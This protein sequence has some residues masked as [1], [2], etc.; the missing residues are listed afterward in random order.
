VSFLALI[1]RNVLRHK[2]RSS[3]TGL[4]VAVAI[5]A[6]FALGVLTH[7]LRVTAISIL[8]TGTADFSVGQKGVSDILYS[9][10]DETEVEDLASYPGVESV[11][12]VLVA[13]VDLDKDHPFFLELGIEPDKLT[14][15]GVQVVDGEPYHPDATDE[16]MLGYRAARDLNKGVGDTLTVEDQQQ[17]F[18]VVGIFSTGQVFGDS[19]SMLPLLTLQG[20]ERKP[21]IITLA[22]VKVKEGVDIDT[23]RA[24]I[25]KEN[26]QLAT[27][28][29][30]SE[31]GRIDRNLKLI[32][33]AN[34]GASILALVIGA[35]GV[36]NTTVMSV[37]QRTR[38]FG[39]LRAVGWSR[40][41][42]L[43]MVM[44]EALLIA[45]A[46]AAA[47]LAAGYVA[48]KAI[49]QAPELIGV[50]QPD[51][52]GDIFGRALGIAIGMAFLGAFYPAVRAAL[53]KPLEALRHE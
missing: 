29:T 36:M 33:A 15:F 8:R 42:V 47:G 9:S 3:L 16:I 43:S 50:F 49:Q 32:S 12:G 46:G 30:E 2:V 37:F 53:L 34:V 26:P 45:L 24:R 21:G 51:Y 17:K 23:L 1:L 22:F 35:I 13:A 10:V 25:D 11:V 7:S 6:V 38:E 39:V 44:S 4:G 5:M 41:R 28:R 27:V 18:R 52:P 14:E 31:F 19:A 20:L 48:V 40:L